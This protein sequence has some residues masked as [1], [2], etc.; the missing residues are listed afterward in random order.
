MNHLLLGKSALLSV[1][2]K[3]CGPPSGAVPPPANTAL[4]SARKPLRGSQKLHITAQG[5]V[6]HPNGLP[7]QF[8][9]HHY[10]KNVCVCVC[11]CFFFLYTFIYQHAPLLMST[12]TC[13]V[14]NFTYYDLSC[15][16]TFY[17]I[18]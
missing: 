15:L 1:R 16:Y 13:I 9:C 18:Y 8:N 6:G 11:V 7:T 3:R 4:K 2:S 10:K 5:T 12:T 14:L 17:N